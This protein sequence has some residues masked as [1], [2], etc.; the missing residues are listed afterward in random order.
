MRTF[1][2][3]LISS[4]LLADRN[5]QWQADHVYCTSRCEYS[6]D[7]SFRQVL[8][9]VGTVGGMQTTFITRYDANIQLTSHFVEF[10]DRWELSVAGRPRLLHVTMRIFNWRSISSTS[11]TIRNCR[12]QVDHVYYTLR[13]K[14]SID[15]PFRRVLRQVETVGGRQTTFITRYDANIELTP[16]CVEFSDR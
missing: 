11:P 12:W 4:S 5:R 1:N 3:R 15:A 9:Q 16:H 13:C 14:Y 2:C 8:R 7:V 10:S 6:T